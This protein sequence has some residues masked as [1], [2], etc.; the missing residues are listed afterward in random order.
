[1]RNTFFLLVYSFVYV[2]S[3]HFLLKALILSLVTSGK[4]FTLKSVTGSCLGIVFS[5]II[6]LFS[7]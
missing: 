1:M 7:A 5:M 6:K 2:F 4:V 3:S